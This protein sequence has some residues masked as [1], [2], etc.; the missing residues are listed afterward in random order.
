[1]PSPRSSVDHPHPKERRQFDEPCKRTVQSDRFV[2]SQANV[3]GTILQ[4]RSGKMKR[5]SG[6]ALGTQL[7]LHA[8]MVKGNERPAAEE[9][10]HR[11]GTTTESLHTTLKCCA[12]ERL[13]ACQAVGLS[14]SLH[15]GRKR[16]VR[17]R[18]PQECTPA[19]LLLCAGMETNHYIYMRA[20]K[21]ALCR[22]H[23]KQPQALYAHE[24]GTA[25][26][27]HEQ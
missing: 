12:T 3:M 14:G 20:R 5:A 2:S 15:E 6:D 25:F 13:N 4:H 17:Q 10:R 18:V 22:S 26:L 24:T 27:V 21:N 16:D 23:R 8:S 11:M 9:C 1:M 7:Q 19:I